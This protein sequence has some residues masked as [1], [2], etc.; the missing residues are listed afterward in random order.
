MY[1]RIATFIVIFI[2]SILVSSCSNSMNDLDDSSIEFGDKKQSTEVVKDIR[3]TVLVKD[4]YEGKYLHKIEIFDNNPE[5][6]GAINLKTGFGSRDIYYAIT[7]Q[8]PQSTSTLY[9]RQT[10]PNKK[11]LL[12]TIAI[13]STSILCDFN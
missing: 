7:L 11:Q 8:I 5:M 13:S 3:I 6:S 12:K 10:D 2:T 9:I 4:L 1:S